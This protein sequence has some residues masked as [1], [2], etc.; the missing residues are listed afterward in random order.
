M[1]KARAILAGDPTPFDASVAHQAI[2]MLLREF[3]DLD[4]ATAE[5]RTAVRLARGARSPRRGADVL[6]ALGVALIYRG[7]SARGLA[8]LRSSL[9]LVTGLEAAHVLVRRGISLW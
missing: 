9:A 2:G 1:A 4:A 5:L 6:A 7:H 8:A 3:G